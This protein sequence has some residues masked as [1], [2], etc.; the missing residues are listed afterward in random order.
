MSNS[1]RSALIYLMCVS[2]ARLLILAK[3]IYIWIWRA[4]GRSKFK[5]AIQVPP[6]LRTH[7]RRPPPQCNSDRT[8]ITLWYR[9]RAAVITKWNTILHLW[10]K[11]Q[12]RCTRTQIAVSKLL[13]FVR[14][15]YGCFENDPST[16]K[17]S[18]YFSIA[19]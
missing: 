10:L 1:Y 15:I 14:N 8:I 13:Y 7:A 5:W 4:L 16:R 19:T 2:T 6:S 17:S 18:K 11:S 12:Y 9:R 3:N